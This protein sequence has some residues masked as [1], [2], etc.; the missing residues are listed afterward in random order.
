MRPGRARYAGLRSLG[1]ARVNVRRPL[2]VLIVFAV[3]LAPVVLVA[4]AVAGSAT[5]ELSASEQIVTF[6]DQVTVSGAVTGDPTCAGGREILL[7]WRAADSAGFATVAQG[8]TASDGGFTFVQSQPHTGRYRATLPADLGCAQATSDEVL[9]RV[10]VFVDAS[11]VVASSEAGSCVDL[12]VIV[13]PD[14]AGQTVDVLRRNGGAWTPVETLTLDGF[15]RARSQPCVHWDDIGVVR[16][17]VRWPAQDT[18]NETSTSPTLAFEVTKAE[19]MLRIDD[20]IGRRSISVSV[21]EEDTFLYR[22]A[23][24]APRT[25]ASNEKLLLAM[26]SLETFGPD[27]RIIT[28]AAAEAFEAGVVRG[29]LWILGRGDP[30]IDRRSLRT[31]AGRLVE[32]GVERVSGSVI[33]ATTYFRRDWFA[34]GWNEVARDYVNRPTALTFEGNHDRH[35]ERQAAVAL[36]RL[37][38]R[39]SVR[40]AEAPGT[41]APPQDLQVLAEIASKDMQTLLAAMLRPSWNFAAEVLGKGLGAEVRGAPGTIAKGAATIE[42]WA[43]DRGVEITAFDGS[44]LSY[45]NRVTA[46][47]LVDLLGQAE[48]ES[49]GDELRRALPTGGQGTLE[50]R[51]HGVRMRAKTGSLEE[52]SSL[53]G[54]VYAERLNAWV[55]FSILCAGMDKSDAVEIEDRI[56]RILADHAR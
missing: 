27:H 23:D 9:V 4:S 15:S 49:W 6:G 55:E 33:G 29:D 1:K 19:W 5:V 7:Q 14:K 32:A 13:S 35:P 21:A 16:F 18:L 47:G 53:S 3:T 8:T 46:A 48:D 20:A 44:G 24:G 54:W 34:P 28:R 39:R 40:V 2:R 10:R 56:V 25:P 45:D 37:L 30:M 26:A 41:G 17:R 22:R 12:T 36:T 51:L 42:A 31:L 38:E 52:V 11:V 50:H 43:G